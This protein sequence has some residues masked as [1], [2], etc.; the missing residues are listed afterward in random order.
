MLVCCPFLKQQ[1][2]GLKCITSAVKRVRENKATFL[3]NAKLLVC[4]FLG[5]RV[6]SNHK[7]HPRE[8]RHPSLTTQPT[9]ALNP[10]LARRVRPHA[11]A[12]F[13]EDPY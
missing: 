5:R 12:L 8:P 13:G 7:L 6:D 10:A 3:T 2:D 9:P 4:R 1:L 11:P